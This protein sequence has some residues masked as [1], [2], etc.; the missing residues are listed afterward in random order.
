MFS[1]QRCLWPQ[2]ASVIRTVETDE[3][4]FRC[5]RRKTCH[6]SSLVLLNTGLSYEVP[7]VHRHNTDVLAFVV[8][9]LDDGP[10]ELLVER[11]HIRS[12][13]V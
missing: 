4:R 10:P 1:V 8:A 12:V 6:T 13:E 11:H 7:G 9:A 3:Q 2:A 5:Q